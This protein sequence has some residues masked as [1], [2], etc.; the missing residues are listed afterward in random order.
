MLCGSLF[1]WKTF[2]VNFVLLNLLEEPLNKVLDYFLIPKLPIKINVHFLKL[3][4][5]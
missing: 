2:R 1:S 3:E 4:G 5:S